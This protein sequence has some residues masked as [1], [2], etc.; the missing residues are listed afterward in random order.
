MTEV[1]RL[2]KVDPER[3]NNAYHTF[4]GAYE[5]ILSDRRI[6]HVLKETASNVG[7]RGGA[8]TSWAAWGSALEWEDTRSRAVQRLVTRAS[9]EPS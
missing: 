4:D 2:R 6:G 7:V 8:S 5:V 3:F 9:G 1:V